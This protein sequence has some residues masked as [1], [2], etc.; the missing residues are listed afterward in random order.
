MSFLGRHEGGG[1]G[2]IL[3]SVTLGGESLRTIFEWLSHYPHSLCCPNFPLRGCPAERCP[4]HP[5]PGSLL[6]SARWEGSQSK[7]SALSNLRTEYTPRQLSSPPH[8]GQAGSSCPR[9]VHMHSLHSLDG[10]S[11]DNTLPPLALPSSSF[12]LV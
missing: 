3:P 5:I 12:P 6:P 11:P 10:S 2:H 7:T 9:L 8:N 1:A 4:V